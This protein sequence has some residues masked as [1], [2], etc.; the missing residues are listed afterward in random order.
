MLARNRDVE[1]RDGAVKR[2]L[3]DVLNPLDVLKNLSRRFEPV[4]SGE[5]PPFQ[6]GLVGYVNY[7]LVRKWERV[8]SISPRRS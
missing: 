5:L 4:C 7:D 3:R 2:V 1:I 8:S 6:G